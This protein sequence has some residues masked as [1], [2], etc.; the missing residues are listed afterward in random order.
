MYTITLLYIWG[1]QDT[2]KVSFERLNVSIKNNRS[3][4]CVQKLT[5]KDPDGVVLYETL[6]SK[7]FFQ[8]PA[9][10]VSCIADQT[11]SKTFYGV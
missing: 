6:E 1:L 3:R 7:P 10:P 2:I 5:V 9:I 4:T 11:P 8:Q